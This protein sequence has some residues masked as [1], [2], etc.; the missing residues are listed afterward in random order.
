MRMRYASRGGAHRAGFDEAWL[1]LRRRTGASQARDGL[2]FEV[3][4]TQNGWRWKIEG[5][6]SVVH[7]SEFDYSSENEAKQAVGEF[8]FSQRN[9]V[10]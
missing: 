2:Y 9:L 10:E 1:P 3:F 7:A 6:G 8:W 4:H 5:D